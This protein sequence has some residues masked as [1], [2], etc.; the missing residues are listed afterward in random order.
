MRNTIIILFIILIY[1][2]A[3]NKRDNLE[4]IKL[5]NKQTLKD[6]KRDTLLY[7]QTK[8]LDRKEHYIGKKFEV[9][10][11]D[12]NIPIKHFLY[13]PDFNNIKRVSSTIFEIYNGY[14]TSN[15]LEKG[16]IPVNIIIAWQTPLVADE[17]EKLII[18]RTKRG[19]WTPEKEAYF[20]NQI[21]GDVLTTKYNLD[22]Y[23]KK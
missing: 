7:V 12:L 13:S 16:E 10:L 22:K 8:I 21:V 5:E 18:D 19:A 3:C 17:L 4:K 6:F 11:S 20:K 23:K 9:L 14:E 2:C 15:K 1:G